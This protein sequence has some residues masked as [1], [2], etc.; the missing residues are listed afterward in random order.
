[1][2]QQMSGLSHWL[3]TG[4]V[5]WL[6]NWLILG[7]TSEWA[8]VML[9]CGVTAGISHASRVRPS[10]IACQTE[11]LRPPGTLIRLQRLLTLFNLSQLMGE[12]CWLFL[13]IPSLFLCLSF[14]L[15]SCEPSRLL[16][17][18]LLCMLFALCVSRHVTCWCVDVAIATPRYAQPRIMWS[19]PTADIAVK[20]RTKKMKCIFSG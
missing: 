20:S 7:A 10:E 5:D 19:S 12:P 13:K 6:I 3:T 11:T 2:W 15:I 18:W 17:S 16:Y 4:L 9:E 14:F 8:V 1:M